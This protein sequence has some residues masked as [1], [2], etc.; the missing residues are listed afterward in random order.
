MITIAIANQKGGVGKT[1]T[2]VNLAHGL[3]LME[4]R[5]LIVDTDPQGHVAVSLGMDKAAGLH[6]LIVGGELLED[7]ARQARPNLW[8][9]PSDKSTEKANRYLTAQDFRERRMADALDGAEYE[10]CIIDLAPS[11]NVLHV[12]SLAASDVVIVPTKLDHLGLDGVNE[13]LKSLWEISRNGLGRM[14]EARILPTFY[15]RVTRETTL[16]FE[17]LVGAYQ[18]Q[19]WAPIPSDTKAREASVYGKTLWEYAPSSAAMMGVRGRGGYIAARD[20][21]AEL[22]SLG[23]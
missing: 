16:Q 7:V 10:V 6:N 20:K 18:E 5:T 21:L 17:A 12:A 9:V 19:V 11:L 22:L 4:W 13:V 23:G 3:A 8:I 14:R 2:A 1:T 15:D